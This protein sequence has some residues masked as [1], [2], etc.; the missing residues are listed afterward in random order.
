MER[1]VGKSPETIE[2]F[3]LLHVRDGLLCY[4][5]AKVIKRLRFGNEDSVAPFA[6]LNVS[7]Q[8]LSKDQFDKFWGEIHSKVP[9]QNAITLAIV[10]SPETKS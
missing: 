6:K 1:S 8:G 7:L 10:E 2:N 9:G 5:F 3:A 4:P